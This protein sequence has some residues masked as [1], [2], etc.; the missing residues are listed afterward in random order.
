MSL[1]NEEA[2]ADLRLLALSPLLIL[3]EFLGN[4]LPG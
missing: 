2:L 4:E 3:L 1:L